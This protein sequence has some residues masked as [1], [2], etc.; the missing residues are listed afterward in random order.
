MFV[1]F[2]QILLNRSQRNRLLCM[3]VYQ[4]CRVH[5]KSRKFTGTNASRIIVAS[6]LI[7][8]NRNTHKHERGDLLPLVPREG[9]P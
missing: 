9:E 3:G 7:C 1:K 8:N 6:E 5:G 2:I 4:K